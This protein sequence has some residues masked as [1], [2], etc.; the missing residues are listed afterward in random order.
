MQVVVILLQ[1]YLLSIF[2]QET[3]VQDRH[4]FGLEARTCVY[5]KCLNIQSMIHFVQRNYEI[6]ILQI[7]KSALI[8]HLSIAIFGYLKLHNSFEILLQLL[9]SIDKKYAQT[10]IFAS[11]WQI[12]MQRTGFLK[13]GTP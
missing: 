12:I 6:L 9:Q 7:L 5:Q 3:S 8:F 10:L 13:F 11:Y 4:L 2:H 1:L